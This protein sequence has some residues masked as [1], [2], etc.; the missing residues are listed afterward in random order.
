MKNFWAIIFLGLLGCSV[1]SA[2]STTSS[3]NVDTP[4][5]S[6]E[7]GN[8]SNWHIYFGD[9]YFNITDSV[10]MYDNWQEQ[11]DASDRFKIMNQMDT[12]D[13][14]VACS[15]LLVVPSDLT[16]TARIGNPGAAEG[17]VGSRYCDNR[18]NYWKAASEKMSYTFTVTENSTLLSYR[19]AAILHVPDNSHSGGQLPMF[20]VNVH[21]INPETGKESVVPCGSY[22][23][24]ANEANSGL[25]QNPSTCTASSASKPGEYVF[26]NWTTGSINL[27]SFIGYEVEVEVLTHDCLVTTDCGGDHAA[28]LTGSHDAYGYFW[29]K[30]SKLELVDKNCGLSDPVIT[31]PEDFTSYVWSRS[32]DKTISSTTNIAT[33]PRSSMSDGVIYSCTMS[34][35]LC[36][37]GTASTELTP[38]TLNMDFLSQDSC[39]GKVSFTNN[40]TCE[41]DSINGLSWSFG[42]STF[43]SKSNPVHYY[44][45]SDSYNVTLYATTKLGC[46]DSVTLPVNVPYFPTLSIDGKTTACSGEKIQLTVLD[47]EVGSSTLWSNGAVTQSITEIADSSK[48]FKVQVTDKRSCSYS[49]QI[50]VSVRPTPTLY[51]TGDSAVCY[52]D[53]ATLIA[54]NAVSYSWSNGSDSN[55]VKV[56]P[57]VPTTYNV[58]GVASNGCSNSSTVSVEVNALPTITIDGPTELCSGSTGTLVASGATQYYW[59]DLFS[60]ASRDIIPV[61]TTKYSVRGTDLNGCSSM[62]SHAVKVKSLPELSYFGDTLICDGEIARISVSG[63]AEWLWFDGTQRNYYSK[64][65]SVDTVWSVRGTSDGCSA[66]LEIPIV[67]KPAPYV[68]INGIPEVCQDDTLKLVAVGADTYSW[69]TGETTDSLVTVPNQSGTYQVTGTGSNGCVTTATVDVSVLPLPTVSITGDASVCQNAI[70]KIYAKGDAKVYYWNT[71]AISDSIKPLITKSQTFSVSGVDL[72]GCKSVDSFAVSTIAPPVLSYTGDSV[73]CSGASVMLVVKGASSYRWFDGSTAAYYQTTPTM[74]TVYTVTGWLNGCSSSLSIPVALHQSPVIWAEGVTALCSGDELSLTAHGG[75]SYLWSTGTSDAVMTSYPVTSSV[76]HLEG[77]DANGCTGT[78][79]VSVTVRLKPD[80]TVSGES[81]V[82]HGST[83]QITASGS[84]VLYT[85]DNGNSGQTINPIVVEPTVYT[86]VGI[87]KYNCKNTASFTVTPV[88]PPDISFLG[89]T[90]TCIGGLI[91]LVGQG[92]VSYIWNDSI[93]APEYSFYPQSNTYVVLT[94]T[95]HNCSSS[96]TIQIIVNNPPNILISGDS[97]VCPG[98]AFTLLAQGAASFKW[99]TGD[100]TASI[101]YSPQVA[102]TYYATGTDIYGCSTTKSYLVNVRSLPDISISQLH[103]SGCPGSADTLVVEA[104]GATYYEWSSSPSLSEV[105]SN[106]NSNKLT[107][108]IDDTT[109]LSLY[110]RDLYGCSSTAELTVS[111]QARISIDFSVEPSWIDESNPA[112]SLQGVTPLEASW[113]WTPDQLSDDVVTGRRASYKYDIDAV[114]DSVKISVKAV[115][116]NGCTYTGSSYVYVW[117]SFWAPT[118][119]TPNAD[120]KNEN[121]HFYGGQYIDDFSF[122]VYDRLGRVVFRGNSFDSSWDGTYEGKPLPWGVYGWVAKYS[123]T[124][125]KKKGER[126]GIISIVR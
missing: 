44:D 116:K 24:N 114:S 118:G 113:T 83:A 125:M 52:G 7:S 110:G 18:V 111:P 122:L 76:Y 25:E 57:M 80:I 108:L 71:G 75:I 101:T 105:E 100:T 70:A 28:N 87:D 23:A 112:V 56:R 6:F 16:L 31:A 102:T 107:V 74:D 27:Q 43:S 2:A 5:L 37:A 92:G 109:T 88:S 91:T 38:V 29:A 104:L 62:A 84:S 115:D 58:V 45:A 35:D 121:F 36:S 124:K 82:C 120:D 61:A 93:A 53:T 65:Q 73:I 95:A 22:S 33:I 90:G 20:A 26:R 68:Y 13:P 40:S 81:E 79:D 77:V 4:N 59:T 96:R 67:I 46:E 34:S 54:H 32:D 72:H 126:K 12:P 49:T 17:L 3:T 119:F 89:D 30:T 64:I 98:D 99:N 39:G 66:T 10:Y 41:G 11:S 69:A 47:A 123:N 55:V 48:Y 21:V 51:I 86:V 42:D 117:K 19:F 50:Y 8:F 63:A 97:A 9:Y 94:G 78:A 1:A 14:I 106:F 60:G 15:N 85:W 103:F